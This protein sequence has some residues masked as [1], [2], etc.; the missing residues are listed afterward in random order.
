MRREIR[1]RAGGEQREKNTTNDRI[2]KQTDLREARSHRIF[3]SNKI[4]F[5]GKIPLQNCIMILILVVV[6]SP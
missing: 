5:N 2:N 6:L 4:N 1:R 3:L